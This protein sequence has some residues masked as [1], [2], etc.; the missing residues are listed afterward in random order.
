MPWPLDHV[1]RPLRAT[2][3]N[4]LW[5]SDS[6]FWSSWLLWSIHSPETQSAGVSLGHSRHRLSWMSQSRRFTSDGPQIPQ[7]TIAVRQDAAKTHQS[8]AQ[9]GWLTQGSTAVLEPAI[10][11]YN[12]SV[13]TMIGAFKAENAHILGHGDLPTPSNRKPLGRWPDSTTVVDW[14]HNVLTRD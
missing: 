9:N 5:V 7:S 14:T 2:M 4:Q 8:N 11:P 1:H 3:L 12:A 13:E 10:G 6:S